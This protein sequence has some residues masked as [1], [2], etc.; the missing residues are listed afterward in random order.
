MKATTRYQTTTATGGGHEGITVDLPIGGGDDSRRVQAAVAEALRSECG[1]E[2]HISV[3]RINRSGSTVLHWSVTAT[4]WPA[5]ESQAPRTKADLAALPQ[6]KGVLRPADKAAAE[7]Q[8][9]E[10]QTR[11]ANAAVDYTLRS[12]GLK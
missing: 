9:N 11:I 2:H 8:A 5:D 12:R 6:T 1:A 3:R 10:F 7:S 4:C